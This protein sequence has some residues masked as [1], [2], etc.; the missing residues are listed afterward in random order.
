[1]NRAPEAP[2]PSRSLALSFAFH[3]GL[4]ALAFLLPRLLRLAAAPPPSLM[5]IEIRSPFLGD[6]PAKL[7]APK[8]FTPGPKAVV[9]A[10]AEIPPVPVTPTPPAPVKAPAPTLT[11]ATRVVS[12]PMKAPAPITVRDLLKPS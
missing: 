11:G 8:A 1:V 3:A 12:D 7:G 10:T 6:G 5:E 4:L 2:P 9:N